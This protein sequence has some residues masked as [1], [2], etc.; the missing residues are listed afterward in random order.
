MFLLA[1]IP[2][3]NSITDV[4]NGSKASLLPIDFLSI[5]TIVEDVEDG[6]AIIEYRTGKTLKTQIPF[7]LL[8]DLYARQGLVIFDMDKEVSKISKPVAQYIK[9]LKENQ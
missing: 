3:I 4:E 1:P 7:T 6:N 8:L 2:D 9:I 5:Q